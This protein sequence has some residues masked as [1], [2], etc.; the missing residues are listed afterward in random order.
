[1]DKLG[2]LWW[3]DGGIGGPLMTRWRNQGPLITRWEIGP[4]AD[5]MGDWRFFDGVMAK[6]RTLNE[7][8]WK[9]GNWGPS[10]PDGKIGGPRSRIL[11]KQVNTAPLHFV[12]VEIGNKRPLMEC[13]AIMNTLGVF[14]IAQVVKS[15]NYHECHYVKPKST[16]QNLLYSGRFRISV[17]LY[18]IVHWDCLV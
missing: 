17:M 8:M 9:L 13:T 11:F 14:V 7:A 1:M 16:E 3:R 2:F 18:I 12:I 15:I 4:L 10:W 5:A 6:L